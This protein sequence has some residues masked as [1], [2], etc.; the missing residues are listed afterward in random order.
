LAQ[1]ILYLVLD[2]SRKE[3]SKEAPR[4]NTSNE[5]DEPTVAQER[6]RDRS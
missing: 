4:L 1:E 2:L 6:K 3:N 5:N